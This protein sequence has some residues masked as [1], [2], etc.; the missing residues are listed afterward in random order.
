MR[1]IIKICRKPLLLTDALRRLRKAFRFS[2][3]KLFVPSRTKEGR[4]IGFRQIFNVKE[5]QP[6]H[7]RVNGCYMRKSFGFYFSMV[8]ANALSASFCALFSVFGTSTTSVI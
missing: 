4:G 2:I 7:R 1:I 8:A 3:Q 5:K 6:K